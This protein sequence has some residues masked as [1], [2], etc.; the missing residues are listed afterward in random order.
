MDAHLQAVREVE[1]V[2][3]SGAFARRRGQPVLYVTESAVFRLGESGPELVE[4]APGLEVERDV[5]GRMG[6]RPAVSPALL[7]LI[8]RLIPIA[9]EH[10]RKVGFCGQAPSNEPAYA[11]FLAD[12]GIDSVSVTPD[13]FISV[14]RQ[15]ADAESAR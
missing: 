4:I 3:F 1:Q 14:K 8:S 5:I 2:T 13:S 6:F 12:E 10:G 11:R 15:I 7:G 9:H